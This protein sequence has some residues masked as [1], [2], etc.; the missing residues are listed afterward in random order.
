M[1]TILIMLIGLL[2][3][4]TAPAQT[5]QHR[6][7]PTIP[8]TFLLTDS[9]VWAGGGGYGLVR[10]DLVT[11]EVIERY[12]REVG[13]LLSDDIVHLQ[14]G[15]DGSI[16]AGHLF[17][18]SVKHRNGWSSRNSLEG[19]A[20]QV[21]PA[22]SHTGWVLSGR[23]KLYWFDGRDFRD[24][25]GLDPAAVAGRIYAIARTA[26]G[27]LWMSADSGL[28]HITASGLALIPWENTPVRQ[29]SSAVQLQPDPAGGFW[30]LGPYL[31]S[32]VYHDPT[33]GFVSY[34]NTEFY[35]SFHLDRLGRIWLGQLFSVFQWTPQGVQDRRSG[36]NTLYYNQDAFQ[37]DDI[38][39]IWVAGSDPRAGRG[40]LTRYDPA[41][42]QKY[43]IPSEHGLWAADVG[44]L[45]LDSQNRLYISYHDGGPLTRYTPESDRWEHLAY[46][47]QMMVIYWEW[48]DIVAGPDDRIWTSTRY[49]DFNRTPIEF[50]GIQVFDPQANT[51]TSRTDIQH[52]SSSNFTYLA[53]SPAG[54]L[55]VSDKT[56]QVLDGQ[57]WGSLPPA[58]N[59]IKERLIHLAWD[60]RERLWALTLNS[61]SAPQRVWMYDGMRWDSV[62]LPGY[63]STNW[64]RILV[65]AYDTKWLIN[66]RGILRVDDRFP[67]AL[68]SSQVWLGPDTLGMYPNE[69]LLLA[70]F[71]PGGYLWMLTSGQRL[72]RFSCEGTESFEI[73][74]DLQLDRPGSFS[75]LVIDRTGQIYVSGFRIGLYQFDP[76]PQLPPA[77]CMGIPAPISTQWHIFPNPAA[78]QLTFSHG[79]P[80]VGALT[81]RWYDTAGRFI[82]QEQ[83]TYGHPGYQ[84]SVSDLQAGL[85]YVQILSADGSWMQKIRVE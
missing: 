9:A 68:G 2:L 73:P 80:A 13:G 35:T 79:N 36:I 45:T 27:T 64:H 81:L 32:F 15:P 55:A 24:S 6:Q 54:K 42:G 34:P 60:Q 4:T 67:A 19:G 77:T 14:S 51:W 33:A 1:R 49:N 41:G 61:Q 82:R 74:Y 38:G 20:I 75:D 7:P 47:D 83:V 63:E 18:L 11:G 66:S 8:T 53:F 37:V 71:D 76:G 58:S 22:T 72:I 5:W 23:N 28:V 48:A 25:A 46:S 12:R 85:Y 65:D 62:S 40:I 57:A 44:R 39:R 29:L 84:T 69:Q 31:S 21:A 3:I 70:A 59:D 17:G 50:E 16:W 10:M 56:V 52:Y 30:L 78:D 26:D 43:Y